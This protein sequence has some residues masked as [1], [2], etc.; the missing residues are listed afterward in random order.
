MNPEKT[1]QENEQIEK[2]EQSI[3][4]P[5]APEESEQLAQEKLQENADSERNDEMESYY[6]NWRNERKYLAY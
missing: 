4:E 2:E 6:G 5:V 1:L 3:G